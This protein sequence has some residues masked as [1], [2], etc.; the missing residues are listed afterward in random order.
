M[1]VETSRQQELDAF[2]NFFKTFDLSRPL[3]NA[4][5]LNDGTIF[6]DILSL[7]YGLCCLSVEGLQC[8]F[9]CLLSQR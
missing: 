8:S 6:F 5:D 7:V 1:S 9:R 3:S 4:V 2:I